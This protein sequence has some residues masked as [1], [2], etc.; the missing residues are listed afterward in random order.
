M[1]T[2]STSKRKYINYRK[3]QM[4]F[5]KAMLVLSIF[6]FSMGFAFGVSKLVTNAY[7]EDETVYFKYYT[8]ITVMPGDTLTSLAEEYGEHFESSKDFINE[9][10]F[11][12]HLLSDELYAGSN[13]I[14]PYYSAEYK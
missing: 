4:I 11:T 6:I 14:V 7:S 3:R 12:N 8:S 10:C 1:K 9:V 2:N 5:R 13:L